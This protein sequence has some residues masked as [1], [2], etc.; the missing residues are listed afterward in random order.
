MMFVEQVDVQ[1]E[2]LDVQLYLPQS[3]NIST[4]IP[5]PNTTLNI[6]PGTFRLLAPHQ[7]PQF[8]SQRPFFYQDDTKTF[9]VVPTNVSVDLQEYFNVPNAAAFFTVKL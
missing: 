2:Q 4:D 3:S 8:I 5:T 7:D 6:T 9:F 1:A